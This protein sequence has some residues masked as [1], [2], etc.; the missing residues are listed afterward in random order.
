MKL[1]LTKSKDEEVFLLHELSEDEFNVIISNSE[2]F[3]DMGIK[4]VIHKTRD[5]KV[6]TN[7][8][9]LKV[10][11]FD[12]SKIID[13]VKKIYD[14]INGVGL[15]ITP[16]DFEIEG[17]SS[18]EIRKII[19]GEVITE[20]TT[21][22]EVIEEKSED[23]EKPVISEEDLKREIEEVKIKAESELK[24]ESK[25]DIRPEVKIESKIE[26]KP[27]IREISRK[28]GKVRSDVKLFEE[29]L[30]K[31]I[32]KIRNELGFS[33]LEQVQ[34]LDLCKIPGSVYAIFG[35]ACVGKT[36]F[37]IRLAFEMSLLGY[38]PIFIVTESNWYYGEYPVADLVR[39][40]FG[41][42]VILEASDVK[43][44]VTNVISRLNNLDTGKRYFIVLDSF[45]AIA[46]AIGMKIL[47]R[48]VEKVIEA[49]KI[50]EEIEFKFE[51]AQISARAIPL[52]NILTKY[53]STISTQYKS[54]AICIAH[55]SQTVMRKW[56]GLTVKPSFGER[57]LHYMQAV[58][59]LTKIEYGGS[60]IRR[61]TCV[62]HRNKHELEGRSIQIHEDIFNI[63]QLLELKK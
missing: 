27:S 5:G 22:S 36:R 49:E 35:F 28:G 41:D 1:K 38:E 46:H 62:V 3:R 56:H 7:R 26:F 60:K 52:L 47:E 19:E 14:I 12:K 11:G 61:L 34:N 45:G 48:E 57:S 31:V 20:S 37:C 54:F 29:S 21:G 55:E 53:L 59:R 42:K 15:K 17:L 9:I 16:S 40:L 24:T 51:P 4:V 8:V 18:D 33:L 2:K 30:K 58:Y 10:D 6:I 63:E 23:V 25:T 43:E 50:G 39:D 13:Y 44:I 32:P